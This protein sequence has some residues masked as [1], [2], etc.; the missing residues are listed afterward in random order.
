MSSF[1]SFDFSKTTKAR[2]AAVPV[3]K[4]LTQSVN[5]KISISA[6]PKT[7]GIKSHKPVILGRL[8]IPPLVFGILVFAVIMLAW[9]GLRSNQSCN[10]SS[11][12]SNGQLNNQ[13]QNQL[14][15]NPLEASNWPQ[16]I[17]N[18]LNPFS[19]GGVQA[20][21]NR[22]L[23]VA[24]ACPNGVCGNDTEVQLKQ[25]NGYTNLLL[26]GV[27]TRDDKSIANTDSMMLISY[28][29][30]SSSTLLL[31]FPRDLFVNYK[32]RDGR[33]L[34]SKV[35]AIYGS[36]GTD[37]LDYAIEQ[38]SGQPVHYH[39]YIT[40]D[41]FS[42]VVDALGGVE[43]ELDK[44]F[45]D[46]YPCKEVPQGQTCPSPRWVEDGMYGLFRF[47]KGKVKLN[48]FDSLVYTRARK[49]SS[50]FDRAAR[51]QKLI[52]AALNGVLN[53]TTPLSQRIP[54]YLE[55]YNVFRSD[56]KTNVELSDI[57]GAMKLAGKLSDRVARVVVDPNLGGSGKIITRGG[58]K[59]GV[60]KNEFVDPSYRTFQEYIS[61]IWQWTPIFIERPKITLAG[62]NVPNDLA[63]QLGSLSEWSQLVISNTPTTTG[64]K[65]RIYNFGGIA[66]SGS[67]KLI[68]SK[69]ENS[70]IFSAEI[71]QIQPTK[72]GEQI[73]V[74]FP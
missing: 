38:I 70:L 17:A 20:N 12:I 8:T 1:S 34:S 13:W 24:N 43:V 11:A 56:V 68:Q 32:V 21:S 25:T 46:V 40:I 49:Y 37:G 4:P 51:Q 35:N 41:V 55:L 64:G 63:N 33:Q 67:A 74:I 71:D 65:V 16:L 52:K 42:K 50:D 18:A 7:G 10:V 57:S 2:R 59:D 61:K 5:K 22:H 26:V 66:S 23:L 58:V 69:I 3:N 60:W 54:Q 29:H 31:S 9:I 47:S 30:S 27:D 14:C 73:L 72:H 53:Q 44:D 15:P 62:N 6:K 48:G 36:H 19:F 39:V 45:V 28:Q